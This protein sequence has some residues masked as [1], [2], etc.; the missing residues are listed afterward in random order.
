MAADR[1][2]VSVLTGHARSRDVG[3]AAACF[4]AARRPV[5]SQLA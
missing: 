3:D 1:V 5:P 2:I 4:A